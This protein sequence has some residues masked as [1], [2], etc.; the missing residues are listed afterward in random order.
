MSDREYYENYLKPL[1]DEAEADCKEAM[2]HETPFN[3]GLC[4]YCCNAEGEWSNDLCGHYKMP[5]W[6]VKRK[7]KCKYF[8]DCNPY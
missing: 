8:S 4:S 6:M 2:L 3:P 5:L 1:M 7:K